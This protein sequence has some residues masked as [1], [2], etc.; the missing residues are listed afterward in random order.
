MLET[1]RLSLLPWDES[2]L[3]NFRQLATDAEVLRYINGGVPWTD[4]Q[5]LEFVTRQMRHFRERGYCMWKLQQ[6]TGSVFLGFCGLQPA[7]VDETTEIEIGWWL[8]PEFWRQGFITEAAN[9]VQRDAFDRIGLTRLIAIIRPANSRS[10]AVA[11]RL[12]MRY[13]R[14]AIYR[15][16]PVSIYATPA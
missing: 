16:I 9:A 11:E 4:E 2:D 1:A 12:G 8:K 14:H 10:I 5:M 3:A 15:D 13:E 7:V 6:R